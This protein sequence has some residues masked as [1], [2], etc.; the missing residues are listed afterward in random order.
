VKYLRVRWTHSNDAFPVLLY[1]EID[2]A[3]WES[4]KV[5]IF[6][7]GRIGWADAHHEVGG[8]TLGQAEIPPLNEI[9]AQDEFEGF[10]IGAE[11]FE[12]A[13]LKARNSN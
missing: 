2:D 8:S 7:D 13:W 1:S 6:L 3:R 12:T 11:E 5:E 9:N 10:E 4:R